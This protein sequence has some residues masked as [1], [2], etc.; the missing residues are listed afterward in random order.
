MFKETF[1]PPSNLDEWKKN[2]E[3]KRETKG[4]SAGR[5]VEDIRK[6]K[7][8]MIVKNKELRETVYSCNFEGAGKITRRD[9]MKFGGA[10]AGLWAIGKYG[11]LEKAIN[12]IAGEKGDAAVVR[13][14]EIKE[15]AEEEIEEIDLEDLERY[16]REE[17]KK[18]KIEF[19]LDNPI[20]VTMEDYAEAKAYWKDRYGKGGDLWPELKQSLERMSAYKK[21]IELI[22]KE[23]GENSDLM[24]VAI[25]E[26]SCVADRKSLAGAIGYYQIMPDTG[27]K[28]GVKKEQ[29][30]KP[31]KNADV[32]K[33]NFNQLL[34]VSKDR[35]IAISGHNKGEMWRYP[36][37]GKEGSSFEDYQN[38]L[39]EQAEK[40]RIEIKS[41]PYIK[42]KV[43][44]GDTLWKLHDI[45]RVD[46]RDLKRINGK[47]E[48]TVK[49]GEVIKIPLQDKKQREYIFQLEIAGY[50]ENFNFVPRVNAVSE[51]IKEGNLT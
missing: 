45:Y 37:L 5:S 31:V 23:L 21:D 3:P 20:K 33:K 41:N 48:D 32:A 17:I 28:W 40:K 24:Y 18:E 7:K 8:K 47:K 13:K 25:P 11:N 19:S 2:N 51:I 26:S 15:G 50:K 16:S 27:V 42:R 46:I 6:E 12:A 38:F 9:F 4:A 1:S 22:F 49:K 35:N 14:T 10:L 30:F 43:K 29:L 44:K 34:S 36:K 39:S